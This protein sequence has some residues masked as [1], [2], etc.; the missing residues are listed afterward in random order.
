MDLLKGADDLYLPVLLKCKFFLLE[1]GY[2]LPREFRDHGYLNELSPT[3]KDG[4]FT[5]FGILTR[6]STNSQQDQE[7]HVRDSRD[8]H[9]N[10]FLVIRSAIAGSELKCSDPLW[11]S[12]P[13]AHWGWSGLH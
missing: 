3:F 2:V 10:S 9:Y 11:P 4:R 7:H 5:L 8:C 13:W 12:V 1:S 6:E